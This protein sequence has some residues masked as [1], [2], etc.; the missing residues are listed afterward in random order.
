MFVTP[1]SFS[2]IT[3]VNI[4]NRFYVWSFTLPIFIADQKHSKN[5]ENEEKTVETD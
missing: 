3:S 4:L 5:K 1:P 2:I